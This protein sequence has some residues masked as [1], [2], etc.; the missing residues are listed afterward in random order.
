MSRLSSLFLTVTLVLLGAGTAAAERVVEVPAGIVRLGQVW[1]AAPADLQSLEIGPSP[2]P[3][4]SRLVL[5]RDLERH[6]SR[7]GV[8]HRDLDLPRALRI[9]TLSERWSPERLR[10]AATEQAIR[11]LP[12]GIELAQVKTQ[13]QQVV[14]AGTRVSGVELGKIPRRAGTQTLPAVLL[15]EYEGAVVRRVP[16]SLVLNVSEASTL[17]LVARGALV[18]VYV[19]RTGARIAAQAEALQDA[20]VGDTIQFRIHQTQRRVHAVVESAQSAR[21]VTR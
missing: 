4:S 19:Q 11:V 14:P 12:P 13:S 1:S 17:P 18:R 5:R 9:E 3:G 15:L 20:N 10:E 8:T 2:P 6:L 21:M 7:A 16:V